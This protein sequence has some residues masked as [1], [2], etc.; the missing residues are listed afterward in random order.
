V[1][2]FYRSTVS[3]NHYLLQLEIP[4]VLWTHKLWWDSPDSDRHVTYSTCDFPVEDCEPLE[5]Y[6]EEMILTDGSGIS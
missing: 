5:D 1:L 2:D 4:F 3:P 6:L